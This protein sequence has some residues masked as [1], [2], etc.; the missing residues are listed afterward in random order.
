MTALSVVEAK[1]IAET[2]RAVMRAAEARCSR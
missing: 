2:K 1:R